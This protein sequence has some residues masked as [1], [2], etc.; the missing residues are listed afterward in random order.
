[1][2]AFVQSSQNLCS[3]GLQQTRGLLGSF[4]R[5]NENTSVDFYLDSLGDLQ[6]P[7]IV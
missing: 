7:K 2:T 1:M 5:V 6:D 3:L 4:D